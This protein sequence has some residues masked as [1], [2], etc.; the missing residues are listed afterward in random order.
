MQGSVSVNTNQMRRSLLPLIS[1]VMLVAFGCRQKTIIADEQVGGSSVDLDTSSN[2]TEANTDTAG[3]TGLEPEKNT[4]I[5]GGVDSEF[6]LETDTGTGTDSGSEMGTDTGTGTEPDSETETD[7]GTG[8]DSGS[9][10]ETDTDTGEVCGVPASFSWTSTGPLVPPPD[11]LVSIKDPTAVSYQGKW[12]VYATTIS[13]S[14]E[15]NMTFLSISDWDTASSAV[16]TP[17]NTNANLT[18]YKAAPQLFHFSGDGLWYLVYQ[19]QEPAYSTSTDPSDV[20]SWS[21]M[22]KFMA[23][24]AIITGSDTGGIDY[25]VICDDTDCYLFFTALNGVLY[26]ATTPKDNFPNGFAGTTQILMEDDVKLHLHDGCSV[27]K[28][29][30][31]GQYLLLVSGIGSTGRYYRAWTAGRLDSDGEDWIPLADTEV[32]AF[33]S[34]Y[35]VANIGWTIDG[36]THGELLRESTDET[37]TINTC[38]MQFLYSGHI[39]STEYPGKDYVLGLLTSNDYS[40]R[41][42]FSFIGK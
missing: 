3:G 14:A 8:I 42:V 18:G 4:D 38:S 16:S 15:L 7:T 28:M 13:A 33:A 17:A 12:L 25:W 36:I 26:R 6:E 23:M 11:D 37:M 9:E 20:G 5:D 41:S 19:T 2:G 30:G 32:T 39:A 24:P 27:Y 10:T 31:T 40:V 1:C 22:T 29:A 21:A 34:A 35:N